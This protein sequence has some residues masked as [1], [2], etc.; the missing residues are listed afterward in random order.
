MKKILKEIL[1]KEIDYGEYINNHGGNYKFNKEGRNPRTT[2]KHFILLGK[3][4]KTEDSILLPLTT[5]DKT[6]KFINKFTKRKNDD[7]ESIYIDSNY[8]EID[9]KHPIIQTKIKVINSDH[10][11]LETFSLYGNKK[12]NKFNTI[13]K[14]KDRLEIK[15]IIKNKQ[16]LKN[17]NNT[18]EKVDTQRNRTRGNKR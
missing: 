11:Y 16:S 1:M 8:I 5:V 3:S 17:I 7:N 2:N 6:D 18:E 9:L 4:K 15:D 12:L 14:I 13:L 10:D